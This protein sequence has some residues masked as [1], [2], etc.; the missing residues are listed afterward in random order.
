MFLDAFS[1]PVIILDNVVSSGQALKINCSTTELDDA[2]FFMYQIL[3]NGSEIAND[4][5]PFVHTI[6]SIKSAESG[7]YT[8]RVS[9]TAAPDIVRI[10]D[11]KNVSGK[12][13]FLI[14]NF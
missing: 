2:A 10:S 4:T 6:P 8:C 1:T 7:N 11:G 13:T 9:L 14:V 5:K 12:N 3:N